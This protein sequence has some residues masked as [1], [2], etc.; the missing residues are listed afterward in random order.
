M[1]N[2][3]AL[4]TILDDVA[5]R[6]GLSGK[7]LE[8]RLQRRWSSIVGDQ[9]AAH[10]RPESIRFRKLYVIVDSSVWIQQLTFLKQSLLDKINMMAETSLISDIVLRVGEVGDH[11]GVGEKRLTP[12]DEGSVPPLRPDELAEVIARVQ[13]VADPE[14]RTRLEEVIARAL[15]SSL[16]SKPYPEPGL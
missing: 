9:V 14:L 1:P 13:A 8:H 16:Q 15:A 4:G 7:L 6:L 11:A 3:S 5:Q 2:L 10:T 12:L